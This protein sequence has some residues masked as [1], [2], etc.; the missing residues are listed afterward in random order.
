METNLKYVLTQWVNLSKN[1]LGEKNGKIQN[2]QN[3]TNNGDCSNSND[4]FCR[5]N[6]YLSFSICT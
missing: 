1:N 6:P 3:K 4:D 5:Y 2:K